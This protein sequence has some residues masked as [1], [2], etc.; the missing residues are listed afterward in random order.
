[1]HIESDRVIL[2]SISPALARRIIA[3][4]ETADDH[5]HPEYPFEDELVPLGHLAATETPDDVFTLY[6]V[7]RRSDG[8]AVGGFGF[9]GPPDADGQVEFGYG[10]VAAA[11]GDGL[12]TEAVRRALETASAHGALRAVADTEITN[13]ASQRVLE[14]AGLHETSRDATMVYYERSLA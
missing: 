14:K 3:R 10:L 6:L 7:R 4:C 9:F 13:R 2:E 12:A 1:M 11:R 8:L 5:W